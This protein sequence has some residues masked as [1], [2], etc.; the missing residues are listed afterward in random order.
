MKQGI[1]AG[2]GQGFGETSQQNSGTPGSQ[3]TSQVR[4][5]SHKN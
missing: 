2:N 5:I 4:V 1:A 3:S